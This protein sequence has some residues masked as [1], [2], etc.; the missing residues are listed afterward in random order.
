MKRCKNYTFNDFL[1]FSYYTLLLLLF[2][3]YSNFT[4][5]KWIYGYLYGHILYIIIYIYMF[6]YI[7]IYIY[8]LI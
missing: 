6:I 7:Y 5:Q 1:C 2:F 8:I 4:K 3:L